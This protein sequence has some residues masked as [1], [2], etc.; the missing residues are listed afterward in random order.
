MRFGGLVALNGVSVEVQRDEIRAIIGPNGAGKSTLFNCLTGVLRPTAGRIEYS[1]AA[2]FFGVE[3]FTYAIDDGNGETDTA[4]VSVTPTLKNAR[5]VDRT[6]TP[7]I[8]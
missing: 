2:D 8:R 1:P 4:T 5:T 7:M 6:I 3:T